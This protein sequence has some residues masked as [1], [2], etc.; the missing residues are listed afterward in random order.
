MTSCLKA[1]CSHPKT[2]HPSSTRPTIALTLRARTSIRAPHW[3]FSGCIAE[4]VPWSILVTAAS[5][6]SAKVRASFTA[7][8]IIRSS[9]SW[10]RCMPSHHW[11]HRR[12]PNETSSPVAWNLP[13]K[14]GIETTPLPYS[15]QTSKRVT[16]L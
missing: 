11:R 7:A 5:I 13:H 2:S 4:G 6:S 10:W 8:R 14:K 3:R 1:I 15:P 9:A 16:S 12:I